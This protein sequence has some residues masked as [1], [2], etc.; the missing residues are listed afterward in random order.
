MFKGRY[1]RG[2]KLQQ[3]VAATN[4]SVSTGPA[5]SCFN[6]LRRHIASCVL[7]NDKSHNFCLI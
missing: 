5:T 6:M 2:D 1:T 4:H 3:Q 7:E